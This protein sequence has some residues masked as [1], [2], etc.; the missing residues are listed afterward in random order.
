VG[1]YGPAGDSG[2]GGSGNGTGVSA[3]AESGGEEEEEEDIDIKSRVIRG[4]IELIYINL[5]STVLS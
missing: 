2:S 1:G 5:S 3:G 4:V